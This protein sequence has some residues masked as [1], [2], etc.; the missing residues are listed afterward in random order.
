MNYKLLL[1]TLTLFEK[2]FDLLNTPL[3]EEGQLFNDLNDIIKKLQINLK[4]II[5]GENNPKLS[6]KDTY[7]DTVG[8]ARKI[9]IYANTVFDDNQT[10][11]IIYKVYK[12]KVLPM[13]EKFNNLCIDWNN[14]FGDKSQKLTTLSVA[15]KKLNEK[16]DNKTSVSEEINYFPY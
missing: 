5:S 3:L 15:I 8:L 10:Q 12:H 9:C 13:L 14:K 2:L 11:M 4:L 6:M 16:I 7:I 1:N